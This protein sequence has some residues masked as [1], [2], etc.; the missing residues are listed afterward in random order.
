MS[1][2]PGTTALGSAL[3][4]DRRVKRRRAA[5]ALLRTP[6]LRARGEGGEEFRLVQ[7]FAAELRPWFERNTGWRLYV[8]AEVAR[9][10]KVPADS[11]SATHPARDPRTKLPFGARRYV[12]VCLAL[13]ALERS[14]HQI[15]LGRLAGQI[16]IGAADPALG[17]AGVEFTLENR[18]ERADLV[19]VVRLLIRLG[20]LT[21]VA[22]D[23]EAYLK[24]TG[25][26]L[27]DV[28]RRVLAGL[29]SSRQGPS[30]IFATDFEDRLAALADDSVLDNDDLRNQR[31]RHHLTRTLLDDPVL[32]YADL[33][34]AE[35]AYLQKQRPHITG[36]ITELT[37]LVAEVRAEGIAMVDPDDELTDVKMPDTGTDGHVTLLLAERLA[38]GTGA[39]ID[40]DPAAD[41]ASAPIVPLTQLHALVREFAREHGGY[42]RKAAT[43][44]GAEHELV[45]Q[46]VGRLTA[47]GLLARTHDHE[48][49]PAVVALPALA[50]YAVGETVLLEPGA[51]APGPRTRRTAPKG[52]RR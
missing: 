20:V 33:P 15:A 5:R 49:A 23:E 19:A 24:A 44:P 28:E 2:P 30:T 6:L 16:V 40:T 10:Y 12:L 8:D 9:L 41:P 21:L 7:Q 22:G 26:A 52:S 43:E 1:R 45:E 3:D 46:A 25:D 11:R 31:I 48:G 18:E 29:L 13:A 4:E 39:G 38:A 36:A 50:R 42:W 32:Y 37:G 14:D 34:D 47:L 17:A 35:L 51:R 27:Y